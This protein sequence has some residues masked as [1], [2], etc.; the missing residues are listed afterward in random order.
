[1]NRLLNALRA[2]HAI[3]ET[4]VSEEQ[5]RPKPDPI[6]LR[7]LKKIKLQL[8]DQIASLERMVSQTA[9]PVTSRL[10]PKRQPATS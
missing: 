8:R 10:R 3:M 9:A 5:R 2:R 7:A 4:R 1:M 6:R